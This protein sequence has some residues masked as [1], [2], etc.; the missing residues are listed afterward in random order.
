MYI[1][2]DS[3]DNVNIGERK[4]PPKLVDETMKH[5][6]NLSEITKKSDKMLV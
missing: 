6:K 3:D 2:D 4:D 1:S 5:T